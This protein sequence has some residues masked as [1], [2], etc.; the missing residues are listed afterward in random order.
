MG[1]IKIKIAI[2]DKDPLYMFHYGNLCAEGRTL[3]QCYDSAT[4]EV[5]ETKTGNVQVTP[6]DSPW[7]LDLIRERFLAETAVRKPKLKLVKRH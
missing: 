5:V 1:V 7:M 3:L 2:N 4:V 6:V